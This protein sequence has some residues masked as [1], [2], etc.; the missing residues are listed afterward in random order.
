MNIKDLGLGDSFYC[1]T[2]EGNEYKVAEHRVAELGVDLYGEHVKFISNGQVESMQAKY[3]EKDFDKC[4]AEVEK[5]N[6]GYSVC[7]ACGSVVESDKAKTIGKIKLCDKCIEAFKEIIKPDEVIE[8]TEEETAESVEEKKEETKQVNE[9]NP[10]A[11]KSKKSAN[12][13]SG[14]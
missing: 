2:Q 13:L 5:V 9:E 12:P 7:S 8:G 6:Q 10:K 11:K 14:I 3:C 4:A 1:L